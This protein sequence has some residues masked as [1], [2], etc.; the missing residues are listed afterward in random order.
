MTCSKEIA[1][2]GSLGQLLSH[3]PPELCGNI[4]REVLKKATLAVLIL[5]KNLKKAGRN[6]YVGND[7]ID[8]GC[9]D[10]SLCFPLIHHHS[11]TLS[12]SWVSLTSLNLT[13]TRVCPMEQN[14]I[15]SSLCAMPNLTRLALYGVL[16]PE[17]LYS[18]LE[19]RAQFTLDYFGSDSVVTESLI[20]FLGRQSELTECS[21]LAASKVPYKKAFQKRTVSALSK[22]TLLQATAVVLTEPLFD[23]HSLR[24]LEF[25]GQSQNLDDQVRAV[26]KIHELS[27]QLESLRFKWDTG[28]V[29]TFLDVTKFTKVA[30]CAGALRYIQMIGVDQNVSCELP[31]RLFLQ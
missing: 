10:C 11:E 5:S 28:K 4:L 21:L 29:G 23:F 30:K 3:M 25:V 22:V 7:E 6:L 9:I 16:S 1:S 12:R 24:R 27:P 15:T 20:K 14:H 8:L 18:R 17:L 19:K 26:N 13:L 2:Y 31:L